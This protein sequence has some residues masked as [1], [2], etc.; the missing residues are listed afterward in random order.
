MMIDGWVEELLLNY[1][2]NI[3]EE[4]RVRFLLQNYRMIRVFCCSQHVLNIEQRKYFPIVDLFVPFFEKTNSI[5]L[6]IDE[7]I[8]ILLNLINTSQ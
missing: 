1:S 3:S 6:S 4:E 8:S 5:R 7:R 2:V